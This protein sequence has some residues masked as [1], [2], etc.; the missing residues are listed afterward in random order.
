M[1]FAWLDG[2]VLPEVEARV[3]IQN[4]GF[5]Y[6]DGCFEPIRIHRG[7]P[8]RL[9]AHIARLR[10]GL[11]ILRIEFA[12]SLD[13][14]RQGA[15][16]IAESNGVVEGLLRI[17]ITAGERPTARGS[18]TITSREL[19]EGPPK[20]ALHVS[21]LAR[22]ISGPMSQCKSISRSVES[23]AP[24]EAH[25]E[26]AFDAILLNE[27]GRVVE[28][29][30]RNL[31]L[32]SGESLQTPPTYDGALPGITRSAVLEIAARAKIRAREMFVSLDRL[33]GADEVFLSG[34]GV[35]VLGIAS[36][37]GRRMEAPGR[38]TR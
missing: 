16:K 32:V 14:L 2:A 30:A 21:T 29:T 7:A 28:T 10:Q 9:G 12:W 24:R 35:G 1:A 34:S 4:R 22:R 26:G 37:D 13:E 27:K 17:T 23:A 6:G 3:P 15:R 11:E 31:F 25:A 19:P 5:L 18:A 38:V 20:P 8:F 36:V 33:R